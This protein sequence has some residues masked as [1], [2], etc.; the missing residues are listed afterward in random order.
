MFDSER[1]ASFGPGGTA[2]ARIE[3]ALAIDSLLDEFHA[4]GGVSNLVPG[5]TSV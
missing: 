3:G 1:S 5:E 2:L 4:S